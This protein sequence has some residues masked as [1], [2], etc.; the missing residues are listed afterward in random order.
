MVIKIIHLF[1]TECL[2]YLVFFS[3]NQGFIVCTIYLTV[4]DFTTDRYLDLTF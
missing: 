2:N 1:V 3:T 4:T